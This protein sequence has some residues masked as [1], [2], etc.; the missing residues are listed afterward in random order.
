MANQNATNMIEVTRKVNRVL[1]KASCT[2]SPII[3]I[4]ELKSKACHHC[5]CAANLN[6]TQ[7]IKFYRSIRM[8]RTEASLYESEKERG[9]T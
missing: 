8:R 6:G 5:Q 3:K 9:E 1:V 7:P 4:Q 2:V